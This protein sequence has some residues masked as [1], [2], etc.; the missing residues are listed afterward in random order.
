MPRFAI[1][2][3]QTGPEELRAQL[4]VTGHGVDRR[5][6]PQG[7]GEFVYAR[8]DQRLKYRFSPESNA[9][10]STGWHVDSDD[11]GPFMW[12]D[13]VILSAR[14]PGQQFHFGMREFAVDLAYVVDPLL[15]DDSFVDPD[16]VDYVGVVEIDDDA[17]NL[18]ITDVAVPEVNGS[19]FVTAPE[20]IAAPLVFPDDFQ[21]VLEEMT[22]VLRR[23][24]GEQISRDAVVPRRIES[25]DED[26]EETR[27]YRLD[28]DALRYRTRDP[29]HGWVL[30][31]TTDSDELL[32]WI[33]DDLASGI[34]WRWA[35][36]A[37]AF[38]EMDEHQALRTL[39]MPY[40][41]VLMYGLRPEWGRRT[42]TSIR[43]LAHANTI[44][45]G[46]LF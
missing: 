24:A 21:P 23:L 45:G 18:D 20:Q 38:A 19:A 33:L 27:C 4:P 25:D 1:R 26:V 9:A 3:L 17:D 22:A 12:V 32:Y 13:A 46:A 15:A 16:R 31:E 36:Q 2:R 7:Q 5:S 14:T 6:N 41:H 35:Q 42:R 10:R 28:A 34:A 8:L 29:L 40:W 37:P 30:R 43:R 11:R 44:R 39:W